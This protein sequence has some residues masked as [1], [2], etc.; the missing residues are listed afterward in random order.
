MTAAH[1]A[2]QSI[3]S[4]LGGITGGGGASPADAPPSAGPGDKFVFDPD[5]VA[6]IVKDW[7]D[8]AKQYRTSLD[9]SKAL[10]QIDSPGTEYSSQIHASVASSSG[11]AYLTSLEEKWNYCL[12][13]ADKFQKSLD[14]YLG[15]E[16]KS[17]ARLNRAGNEGMI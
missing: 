16:H 7:L 9:T 6:A 12:D 3:D 14:D 8:L 2:F 17:V 11:L 1:H 15:V 4:T 10:G 13:E 5:E